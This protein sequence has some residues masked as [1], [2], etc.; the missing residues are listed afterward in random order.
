MLCLESLR[1]ESWAQTERFHWATSPKIFSVVRSGIYGEKAEALAVPRPASGR[2]A[3]P[4]LYRRS[5]LPFFS[6]AVRSYP[7]TAAAVEMGL[8]D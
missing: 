4:R 5:T 8:R 1:I 6:I 7:H 2:V 3:R